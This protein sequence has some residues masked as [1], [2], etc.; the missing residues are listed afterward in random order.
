MEITS[1]MSIMAEQYLYMQFYSCIKVNN[2]SGLGRE[3]VKK[4][5]LKNLRTFSI[6]VPYSHGG[7]AKSL[8]RHTDHTLQLQTKFKG[9]DVTQKS[10]L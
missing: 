7:L 10:R 8:A 9:M 1:V 5:A 2:Q 3:T 6:T 4:V